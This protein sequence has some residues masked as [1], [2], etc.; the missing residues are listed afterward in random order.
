[1]ELTIRITHE[2]LSQ[3]YETRTLEAARATIETSGKAVL[4]LINKDIDMWETG[5]KGWEEI[6]A[7][8]CLMHYE[9]RNHSGN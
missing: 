3:T 9:R 7:A 1:M 6:I 5:S 4:D 8:R 2:D